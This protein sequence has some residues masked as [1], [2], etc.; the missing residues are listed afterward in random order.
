MSDWTE[1]ERCRIVEHDDASRQQR[2]GGKTLP[3]TV[4]KVVGSYVFAAPDEGHG[5]PSK[6]AQF[7]ASSGWT[8]H[9]GMF[10]WRLMPAEDTDAAEAAG[11]E[12]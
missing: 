1:G 11:R 5:F 6:P 9:D 4:T 10:R 7:W 12:N 8:A 3:A 2:E